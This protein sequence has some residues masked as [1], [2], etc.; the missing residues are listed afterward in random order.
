MEDHACDVAMTRLV[1]LGGTP[2][3]TYRVLDFEKTGE[4]C[5][6][7]TIEPLVRLECPSLD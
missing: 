5:G 3:N 6:I 1:L 4:L 7:T 2:Y